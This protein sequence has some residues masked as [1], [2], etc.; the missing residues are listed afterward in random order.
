MRLGKREWY[1]SAPM[2]DWVNR[3]W[4]MQAVD[5]ASIWVFGLLKD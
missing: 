1:M 2:S 5:R 4:S 3:Q